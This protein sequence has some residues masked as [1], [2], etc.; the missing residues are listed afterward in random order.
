MTEGEGR[1]EAVELELTCGIDSGGTG[2]LVTP[3]GLGTFVL[4]P[5]EASL[6]IWPVRFIR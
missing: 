1:S 5:A 6:A 3:E 4:T 2:E